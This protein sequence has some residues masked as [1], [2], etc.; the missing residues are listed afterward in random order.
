MKL[1]NC[2]S[3]HLTFT[4][5]KKTFLMSLKDLQN[6]SILLR[7]FEI[8]IFVSISWFLHFWFTWT[9]YIFTLLSKIQWIFN[10]M[11]KI[12][13]TVNDVIKPSAIQYKLDQEKFEHRKKT[14]WMIQNKKEILPLHFQLWNLKLIGPTFWS[15]FFAF[16]W[17][18]AACWRDRLRSMI[19]KKKF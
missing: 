11:K 3:G 15:D 18:L 10:Q 12:T 8:V 17:P 4:T 1:N 13:I 7:K 6:N 2:S 19:L 16:R 9:H 5:T 14:I